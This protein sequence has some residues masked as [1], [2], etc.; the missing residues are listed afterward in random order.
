M[1]LIGTLDDERQGLAFSLFLK[2]K[3]I[4]HQLDIHPNT[5]WGSPHYGSTSCDIW[6]QDE[7]QVPEALKWYHFFLEHPQD[8][9]FQQ[10]ETVAWPHLKTTQIPSDQAAQ[11]TPTETT[12]SWEKQPMGWITRLLLI[13]C[14]G[15]FFLSQFTMPSH[16]V[17]A[18]YSGL[19]LFTSPV[20]KELLFDYPKFYQLINQFIHLY[21]YEGLENPDTLSPEGRQLLQKINKTPYWP[22]FYTLL[23][24]R[25]PKSVEKGFTQYP[26][27]EKIQQGQVWRLF[28]PCLLHGDLFHLFFNM[29]WLIVLGKQIEQRLTSGR[30]ILFILSMGI[31]SNVA[32]YLISGPNFIGFSGILCGMLAFIWVR[33]YRA[34]WEG[35]QLD[36][37]TLVFMLMFILGMAGLQLLSFLL[38][39]SLDMSFSIGLANTAHLI[40]GVLGYLFGRLNFFSWRHF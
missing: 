9:L 8:P 34:A 2:K 24:K 5:D 38:E 29:I 6:I 3:G 11:A 27:F 16:A 40:G 32:Q 20:E 39:K 22:G 35:Y 33:Q 14:C 15:L 21:G 30:Y 28:T 37:L 7:D 1:R 17:P 26:L 10:T 12:N 25:G 18:R 36:R 13:T 23:L 4:L 19:N 31:L